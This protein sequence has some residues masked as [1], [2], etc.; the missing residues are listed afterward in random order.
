MPRIIV[1]SDNAAADDDAAVLLDTRVRSAQLAEEDQA[2]RFIERLGWAISDAE[3]SD[4]GR[5]PL[6]ATLAPRSV[7]QSPSELRPLSPAPQ[8]RTHPVALFLPQA[9]A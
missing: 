2:M 1:I 3:D 7:S 9:A 5:A 6:N 8:R 4:H